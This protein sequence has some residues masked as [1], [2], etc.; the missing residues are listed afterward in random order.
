MPS[1]G[2]WVLP[3]N[4]L[5]RSASG[6]MLT[7]PVTRE[8]SSWLPQ[9]TQFHALTLERP[10]QKHNDECSPSLRCFSLALRQLCLSSQECEKVSIEVFVLVPVRMVAT[11]RVD[12]ETGVG[13]GVDDP[14]HA[15]EREGR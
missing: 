7:L 12:R 3:E 10:I 1:L 11:E 15:V 13:N 9:V 8:L 14:L 2:L 5:A 6:W 4:V